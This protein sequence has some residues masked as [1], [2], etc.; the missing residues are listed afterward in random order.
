MDFNDLEEPD[1][2]VDSLIDF[3]KAEGDAELHSWAIEALAGGLGVD[4]V[5][6]EGQ[7]PAKR[8]RALGDVLGGRLALAINAAPGDAAGL[9][10]AVLKGLL[11]GLRGDLPEPVSEAGRRGP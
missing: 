9:V 3:I 5:I 8:L 11:T 6:V 4:A 7:T 10:E 1:R 2:R